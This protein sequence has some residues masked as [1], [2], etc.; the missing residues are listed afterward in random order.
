[1][2]NIGRAQNNYPGRVQA[3]TSAVLVLV[4]NAEQHLTVPATATVAVFAFTNNVYICVN[5][6][7]AT[8]PSAS[9]TS[10]PSP[11]TVPE[12][13]PSVLS[14]IPG[15]TVSAISAGSCILLISFY[16]DTTG[17]ANS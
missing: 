7:T 6:Q 13:N 8:V 15:G 14:V 10:F 1:M 4:A 5:G 12:L 2:Q 11:N 9:V 16:R 3:D 17:V